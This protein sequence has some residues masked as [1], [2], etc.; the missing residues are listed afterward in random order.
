LYPRPELGPKEL[1]M[2]MQTFINLPV[3]DLT[4]AS[5]FFTAIGFSIYMD[6]TAVSEE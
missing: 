6:V 1:A 5:E 2:G 3:K 4:K